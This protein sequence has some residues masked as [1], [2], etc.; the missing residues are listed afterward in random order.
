MKM[1]KLSI[2]IGADTG[3][4]RKDMNKADSIVNKFAKGAST[5]F[6]GLAIAAGAA[7]FTIGKQGIEAAI[8]GQKNQTLLEASIRKT[9]KATDEAIAANEELIGQTQM[10]Y[11]IDDVELRNS[12]LKLTRVT[13]SLTKAQK[14]QA[15]AVDVAAGANIDLETATNLIVK[16]QQGSFTGFKKIGVV[17][18][19][20]TVKTKDVYG[21]METLKATFKGAA[22]VAAGTLEG[23]LDRLNQKWGETEEAVGAVLLEGL[24]PLLDWFQTP[25]AEAVITEFV[26]AF[27]SGIKTIST[28][29]PTILTDLK[30]V[31]Q[32]V[33]NLGIDTLFKN[34]QYLAAAAAFAKFPGPWQVKL[35]AAAAAYA[36]VDV[37]T[38]DA[39]NAFNTAAQES[40][41][42]KGARALSEQGQ[43]SAAILSNQ[44]KGNISNP[45]AM[46]RVQAP[47]FSSLYG[48]APVTINVNGIVDAKS[49]AAAVRKALQNANSNGVSTTGRTGGR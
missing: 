27:S 37:I 25:E 30:K 26:D 15:I 12:M 8:E 1:P 19:E 44:L 7:A 14:L 24:E 41:G 48:Q 6:N 10:R 45:Y 5:A 9:T 42:G 2:S 23:K 49:A 18:D 39:A 29:L 34:P 38:G 35:L 43:R 22:D 36:G 11:G 31:G 4:L 16:A 46:Q 40:L 13:G 17:L 33:D 3:R 28:N 32:T 20:Q 21:A 47:V